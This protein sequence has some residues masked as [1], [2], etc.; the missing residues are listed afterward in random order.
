MSDKQVIII[1]VGPADW[2]LRAPGC[3]E[4]RRAIKHAETEY[5]HLPW[6][7]RDQKFEEDNRCVVTYSR[8]NYKPSFILFNEKDW[9]WFLMKWSA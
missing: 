2:E 6:A 9:T 4:L 1:D 7:E 8:D 5:K 3:R